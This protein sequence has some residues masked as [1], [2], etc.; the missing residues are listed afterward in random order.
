[1]D[2]L[3]ENVCAF[4][5][6]PC[7]ILHT[8]RNISDRSFREYENTPFVFNNS[9]PPPENR[10]VH[11]IMWNNLVHRKR[12]QM[13]IWRMCVAWWITK[14]TNIHSEFLILKLSTATTLVIRTLPVFFTSAWH[15]DRLWA[16]ARLLFSGIRSFFHRVPGEAEK[17]LYL[18]SNLRTLA[19]VSPLYRVMLSHLTFSVVCVGWLT[20]S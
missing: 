11:E 9:P 2:T 20:F 10:A 18:V 15:S 12:P 13:T 8:M 17:L 19:A 16:P 7:W 6:I 5:L 4:M 14:A 1:M 3:H